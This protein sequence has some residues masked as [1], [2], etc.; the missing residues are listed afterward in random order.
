MATLTYSMLTSLDGFTAG[1][2]GDFD[3][4]TPTPLVHRRANAAMRDS[5]LEIYGRSMYQTMRVWQD[6]DESTAADPG[7]WRDAML[8]FAELWR[9][10]DKLVVSATL[11]D[12]DTPRTTLVRALDAA[13]LRELKTERDGHMS[14]SGP[15]T[16]ASALHDGLVDEVARYIAPVAVGGGTPWWPQG[17]AATLDLLEVRRFDAGWVYLRYRVLH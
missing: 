5:S 9:N 13:R 12:V 2:D 17:V 10:T 16:A 6:I 11:A 15:T 7:P 14:I 4:A 8:E 3:W 1:P